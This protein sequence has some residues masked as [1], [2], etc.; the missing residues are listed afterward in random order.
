MSR[1]DGS[2][3]RLFLRENVQPPMAQQQDRLR[4]RLERVLDPGKL[5]VTSHPSRLSRGSEA[6]AL[7]WYER[8]A[9]WATARDVSL[10]PFFESRDAYDPEA[11]A[12]LEM[13]SLPVLWLVVTEG[14]AVRT[15]YPHVD[16]AVV[17]VSSAVDDL[18][19]SGTP[20]RAND[21]AD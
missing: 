15:V 1:D 5:S 8:V 20:R 18:E 3:F 10:S 2:R 19:A 6:D 14:D 13:V 9:E 11:D 4:A 7:E 16:D 17:P 21:A 12:V